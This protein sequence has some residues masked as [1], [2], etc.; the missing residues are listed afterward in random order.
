MTD[1]VPLV[2]SVEQRLEHLGLALPEPRSRMGNFVGSVH[3]GDLLFLS[4][5]GSHERLG[6]IGDDLGLDDGYDAAKECVLYLLGLVKEELG[7]LDRVER[8]VKLLG[9]VNCV[10]GFDKTPL[11]LNGAS[12]LLIH[13]YGEAGHHART[14]IGVN[15]LP[16]NF[17]VEIEMIVQVK[18]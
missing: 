2:H 13:L 16:R 18:A 9:F 8:I 11:I 6:T 12:D 3:V 15:A 5:Q 10:P 1:T 14:A 17:A 4:G 7:T